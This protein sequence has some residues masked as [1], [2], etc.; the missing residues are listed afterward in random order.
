[1]QICFFGRTPIRGELGP[2]GER[3]YENGEGWW[4]WEW[5]FCLFSGLVLC[6]SK[7][8]Y[9]LHSQPWGESSLAFQSHALRRKE[10]IKTVQTGDL[11]RYLKFVHCWTILAGFFHWLIRLN[12]II[13][14]QKLVDDWSL[15]MQILVC[16]TH[17]AVLFKFSFDLKFVKFIN[18]KLPSILFDFKQ[19]VGNSIFSLSSL[20]HYRKSR[21]SW[22]HFYVTK[23]IIWGMVFDEQF[24][25][26]NAPWWNQN[27]RGS[28]AGTVHSDMSGVMGCGKISQWFSW[29]RTGNWL[30][31]SVLWWSKCE[32]GE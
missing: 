17:F 30:F 19:M 14:I 7:G 20:I 31:W 29:T 24:I 18:L 6:S 28:W 8:G 11:F 4:C 3:K 10:K 15:C 22:T 5:S 27:K 1:M 23:G 32:T 13:M 12:L 25:C 16:G 26:S 9:L 2:V 21:T